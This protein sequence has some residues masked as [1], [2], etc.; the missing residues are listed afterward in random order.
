MYNRALI[1][2]MHKLGVHVSHSPFS[3]DVF[4]ASPNTTYILDSLYFPD[5]PDPQTML[6][7]FCVGL[8]HHLE[9]LYQANGS[10]TGTPVLDYCK[11]FVATSTFT[12]SYLDQLGYTEVPKTVIEPVAPSTGKSKMKSDHINALLLANLQ[13][14][15][16][17]LPFLEVLARASCPPYFTI[18]I[19][20]GHQADPDYAA[21]CRN[22]LVDHPTLGKC[23]HL[24]GSQ[25]DAALTRLFETSNLFISTSY[26]ET[27]GMAI[28]EAAMWGLPL[29]VLRGGYT[30]AHVSEGV[31]GWVANDMEAL[32]NTFCSLIDDPVG[33]RKVREG[34][35][36]FEPEY[37]RSWEEE[38]G[39]LVGFVEALH[40]N[41]KM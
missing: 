9:S 25:D 40:G 14:R 31:N 32:V 35:L 6:P 2:A 22:V 36:A 27:F 1:H 18:R 13:A 23:V 19:V 10:G 41:R 24:L 26:M 28:Q 37:A 7:P 38:A 8:V 30:P 17:I 29:L 20:G 16:G 11:G 4:L 12:A 21:Q 34:A 5:I 39:K 33:F 3:T 15:K